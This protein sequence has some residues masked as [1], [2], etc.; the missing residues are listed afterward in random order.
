M[1][2]SAFSTQM[3]EILNSLVIRATGAV[4]FCNSEQLY[5]LSA[6]AMMFAHLARH[7]RNF[8]FGG[9]T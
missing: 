6:H 8:L 3:N 2:T 5:L 7:P 4:G 9:G 1:I